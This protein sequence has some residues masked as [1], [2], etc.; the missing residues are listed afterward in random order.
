LK[1]ARG[2]AI[3]LFS[4][5]NQHG[6]ALRVRRA[7]PESTEAGGGRGQ[8]QLVIDFAAPTIRA[9]SGFTRSSKR[10]FSVLAIVFV[11]FSL[12]ACASRP[13]TGFLSPAAISAP[14][15]T[16]H[17]LL[18]ATTRERDPRPDILQWGK[19]QFPQ[20]RDDHDLGS[21]EARSRPGR[22][23]GEPARES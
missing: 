3:G 9:S 15:E 14:G 20:L 8:G 13:E 12:A 4:V 23:A 10:S 1:S 21:A 7:S 16:E 22:S 17:T 19:S 2:V 18:V 6:L 5:L 11:A